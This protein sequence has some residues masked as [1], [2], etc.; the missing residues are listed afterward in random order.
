MDKKQRTEL[1]ITAALAAVLLLVWANS[2]KFIKSKAAAKNKASQV[3]EPLGNMPI[4]GAGVITSSVEADEGLPWKRCPFSGRIYSGY[5]PPVQSSSAGLTLSGIIWDNERPTAIIND[6][7][8]STG[9]NI[10]GYT[11]IEIKSDK[12]ILSDGSRD[13]EIKVGQ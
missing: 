5:S 8:V 4:G 12:V 13:F 3:R 9:A 7:I 10:A 1:I 11:V 2:I 6:K